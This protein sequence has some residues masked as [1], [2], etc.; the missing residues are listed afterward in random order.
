M[1]YLFPTF[2]LEMATVN[3]CYDWNPGVQA[4]K[5]IV[6]FFESVYLKGTKEDIT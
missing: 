6:T 4:E 3:Y 2:P 5:L 1:V